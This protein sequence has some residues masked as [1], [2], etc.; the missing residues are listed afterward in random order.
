MGVD[1]GHDITKEL[2]TLR[3][4]LTEIESVLRFGDPGFLMALDDRTVERLSDELDHAVITASKI[5]RGDCVGRPVS[6]EE[7]SSLIDL[8]KELMH[9]SGVF[10]GAAIS[11]RGHI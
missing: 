1:L 10:R 9:A 4:C 7:L 8:Q 5:V 6:D 11:L 3:Y 2:S